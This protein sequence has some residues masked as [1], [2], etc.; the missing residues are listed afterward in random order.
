[1]SSSEYPPS[2]TLV[3]IDTRV[4]DIRESLK[5]KVDD[6]FFYLIHRNR[7]PSA[8]MTVVQHVA[9]EFLKWRD[10]RDGNNPDFKTHGFKDR[11]TPASRP[12]GND[13]EKLAVQ[14]RTLADKLR[15][16]LFAYYQ[17]NFGIPP[18]THAHLDPPQSEVIAGRAERIVYIEIPEGEGWK[19][20]IQ[21]RT[22]AIKKSME[23]V[24]DR[25]DFKLI[26]T[27]VEALHY[28]AENLHLTKQIED[29]AI[30]WDANKMPYPDLNGFRTALSGSK[31][32]YRLI[33]GPVKYK[34]YMELLSDV[35]SEK[36]GGNELL[37]CFRL[38]RALP[39]MNFTIVY[40]LDSLQKP[41]EVLYGYG[42][43]AGKNSVDDTPVFLTNNPKLVKEYKR[44]FQVLREDP[45]SCRIRIHD[46][47]FID[48]DE[49]ENDIVTTFKNFGEVPI[50]NLIKKEPGGRVRLC[51]T[52]SSE[53]DRLITHFKSISVSASMQ[54]L[55]AHRDSPFLKT[56]EKSLSRSLQALVD[57]NLEALKGLL[58]RSNLTVK[59]TG[60]IMPVMLKQIGSTIIFSPFWNGKPVASGPQFMVR[61]TS[62][63]G[64]SLETQFEE[65][66]NDK[67]AVTADF[68]R[69][70]IVVPP[71]RNP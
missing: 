51:V 27:N 32:N 50:E 38:D 1:M 53:I 61:A 20:V 23:L 34:A 39:M 7:E 46:P 56:R 2:P 44:L 36:P 40:Y 8:K 64:S 68:S 62:G 43:K 14:V 60:K 22:R 66:W 30:R 28:L 15:D 16:K 3:E 35:Y 49:T 31:A 21:W 55:L 13:A 69:S 57:S 33:T 67:D 11:Y 58:P 42:I 17:R 47:D 59:L 5:P 48:S 70:E 24:G 19:P 37:E 6:L 9:L 65:L 18:R 29:T 41:T 26:G 4:N 25:V 52:C 71:L 12:K 10:A 63:T 45:S 54:I